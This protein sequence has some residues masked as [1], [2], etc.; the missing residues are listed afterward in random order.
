MSN[1]PDAAILRLGRFVQMPIDLQILLQPKELAVFNTIR[2]MSDMQTKTISYSLFTV[3][4]GYDKKTIGSAL[5]SLVNL[6]LV[7]AGS[8]TK[9]GTIY[10]IKEKTLYSI[11][12]K[13]SDTLNPVERMRVVDRFRGEGNEIHTTMIRN[14]SNTSFDSR[15]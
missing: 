12:K 3:Y 11:I 6:G 8:V 9:D 5:K 14:Y 7:E 13:L 1:R 10:T 15:Q 2:H 4:T